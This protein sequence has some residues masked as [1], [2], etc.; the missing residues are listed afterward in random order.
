MLCFVRVFGTPLLQSKSF[1]S[2][3]ENSYMKVSYHM[4]LYFYSVFS[5]KIIDGNLVRLFVRNGLRLERPSLVISFFSTNVMP[6]LY[7]DFCYT[8]INVHKA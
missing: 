3:Q 7:L 1:Y 5:S 2:V 8:K 6:S 4:N